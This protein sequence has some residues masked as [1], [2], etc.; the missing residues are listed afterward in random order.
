M[1]RSV[2]AGDCSPG[3]VELQFLDLRERFAVFLDLENLLY[4]FQQTGDLEAGGRLLDG[5]LGGISA[6][7][8]IVH[9]VAVCNRAL[10]RRMALALQ[11]RGI[12]TFIHHGGRN[13]ADLA[14]LQ[15]IAGDVPTSCETVVI[16]S[17]DGIFVRAAQELQQVGKRVEAIGVS[18]TISDALR[19]EA[20]RFHRLH[21]A[22]NK[23]RKPRDGSIS[24]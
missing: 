16:G 23:P 21:C 6:R 24:V 19:F 11:P 8:P 18:G 2:M 17:G 9:G 22:Q 15:R 12:R 5:I 14:L 7:G 1:Q 3:T 13:A 4:P 10:A 20:H